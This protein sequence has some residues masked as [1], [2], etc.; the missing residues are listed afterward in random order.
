MQE[1]VQQA[2]A[3]IKKREKKPNFMG[4]SG[5]W[6]GYKE[7][8]NS[9][10]DL[11]GETHVMPDGTTMLNS[12]MTGAMPEAPPR[13]PPERLLLR[14]LIAALLVFWRYLPM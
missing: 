1:T 4:G 5:S 8:N 11:T 9:F 7:R 14:G 12:D 2:M 6:G 3:R 10:R 13:T